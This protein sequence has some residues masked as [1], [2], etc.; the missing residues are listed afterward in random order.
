[1]KVDPNQ[2]LLS[3]SSQNG[4]PEASRMIIIT[5]E[6]RYGRSILTE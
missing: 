1:M 5:S 3:K 4:P 2:T 6:G